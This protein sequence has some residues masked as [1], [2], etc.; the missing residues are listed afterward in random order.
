MINLLPQTTDSIPFILQRNVVANVDTFSI[1]ANDFHAYEYLTLDTSKLFYDINVIK[2]EVVAISGVE[3]I[4]RPLLNQIEGLLFL[5]FLVLFLLGA[6]VFM[7]AGA[8]HFAGIRALFSFSNHKSELEQDLVITA[9]DAWSKFFYFVQTIVIYSILFFAIIVRNSTDYISMYDYWILFLQVSGGF[10]FF[11]FTKYLVYK[12]MEG[13]FS[14]T[15]FN[16]L[17]NAFFSV[18][19]LAGIIGFLP[20]IIYFYIPETANYMLY[21]LFGIFLIGRIVLFIQSYQFF[22]KAHIGSS[23]FFIYLCGIEI[24]PYFLLYKAVVLIN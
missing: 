22:K 1:S 15:R 13:V 4:M 3:G 24:M 19:Y 9:S 17:L 16:Y 6:I 18:F 7:Y 5:I 20:I 23:Y 8:S 11:V 14:R 2:D 10:L 12:V 21:V